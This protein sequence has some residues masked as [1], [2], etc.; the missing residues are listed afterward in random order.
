MF[1]SGGTPSNPASLAS[2]LPLAGSYVLGPPDFHT[3]AQPSG[4]PA[5]QAE[6]PSAGGCRTALRPSAVSALQQPF[7]PSYAL[8]PLEDEKGATALWGLQ[9][10]TWKPPAGGRSVTSKDNRIHFEHLSP[11]LPS[12]SI[13]TLWGFTWHGKKMWRGV[14]RRTVCATCAPAGVAAGPKVGVPAARTRAPTGGIAGLRKR[15]ALCSG[16]VSVFR[17]HLGLFPLN[18]QSAEDQRDSKFPERCFALCFFLPARPV[19]RRQGPL[20]RAG[21]MDRSA[22]SSTKSPREQPSLM[23]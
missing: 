1:P 5:V 4:P 20:A 18:A 12:K 6:I 15:L 2:W 9:K 10:D 3:T 7:F 14:S 23:L 11:A 8:L 17:M 16:P 13:G 22:V 21:G 19:R